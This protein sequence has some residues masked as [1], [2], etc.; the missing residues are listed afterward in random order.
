M[1]LFCMTDVEIRKKIA[2]IVNDLQVCRSF[3]TGLS[4]VVGVGWADGTLIL[5]DCIMKKFFTFLLVVVLVLLCLRIAGVWKSEPDD[6][7][8]ALEPVEVDA[9]A[10]SVAMEQSTHLKFKGVPIDGPLEQFVARM[11]RK[12]F[13]VTSAREEE[14]VR[15]EGDFAGFKQCE[16][17][18]STLD[19]QNLVSRIT[20]WFPIQDQWKNLYGDYKTLK[21]MLTEKYGKPTSCV[22]RFTGYLGNSGEEYRM[23][24][25]RGNECK[26]VTRFSGDEG[27]IILSIEYRDYTS[28]F[29]QLVYQDK[30]NGREVRNT[31]IDDL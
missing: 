26:Y 23:S 31:A 5:I 11:V 28:C 6:E 18:V 25:V 10:D 1:Q 2:I 12:G 7:N 27:D 30:E 19:N 20:V 14:V 16:V 3:C 22:E 13:E 17:Y 21:E 24:A 9:T 15:L 8:K 29:V 4:P